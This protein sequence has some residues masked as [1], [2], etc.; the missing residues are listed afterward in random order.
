MTQEFERRDPQP[1][2]LD[3][4]Q[5]FDAL[6]P[7]TFD[8]PHELYHHLREM[9][10]V[11]YS[12]SWNGFWA[13]LGYDDVAKAAAN[14]KQ[15]IT[16]VQN[17]VPKVAYTGRRPPLH[18]DPPDHTPFRAALNPLFNEARME[19]LKEPIRRFTIELLQPLIDSGQG[20]ICTEVGSKMPVYVFGEWMNLKGD[21]LETLRNTAS[22][23]VYAVHEANDDEVKRASLE[24][25]DMARKLVAD[26]RENPLDAESDFTTALIST[27]HNGEPLNDE[28]VVGTIRQVLV[29][30]IVAPTVMMGSICVHLSRDQ[31]LQQKLRNNPELIP[32]AIE[33]FL[34][35]YTPY[36]GFARTS[37]EDFELHGCPIKK[38]QP[39]ALVYAAAN[40]DPKKFDN[41]DEFII[42]RH[43]INDSLAF[44]RG[45]H[46][47]PGAPIAR[48][49]LNIALE[50]LLKRTSK[51][52]LAGEIVPTRM[53][54]IGAMEVPLFFTPN[55]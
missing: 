46:N 37:V 15:F 51:F 44:G 21:V 41:P 2:K 12:A 43:N 23:F 14:S 24:L 50:E 6:A 55:C 36:R 48:L 10:P 4:P 32:A 5:D 31:E 35:L 20:D 40:R 7:E 1:V 19:T 13:F 47:C 17:V 45:P 30:G 26:R 28:L 9:C 22:R 38:D 49:E 25:Y 29:V 53:P 33:E 52:E 54:E 34:R 3:R 42:D 16:S 11:A 8:S 39:I 27:R 18:L